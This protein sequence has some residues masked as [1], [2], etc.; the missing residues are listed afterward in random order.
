MSCPYFVRK[1]LYWQVMRPSELLEHQSLGRS[2]KL[3][4]AGTTIQGS[5]ES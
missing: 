1:G 3:I 4:V 2:S 5:E